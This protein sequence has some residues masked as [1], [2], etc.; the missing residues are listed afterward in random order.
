MISSPTYLS[1]LIIEALVQLQ[2]SKLQKLKKCR[3]CN[4]SWLQGWLWDFGLIRGFG[5]CRHLHNTLFDDASPSLAGILGLKWKWHVD[6]F[7][8]RICRT[9]SSIAKLLLLS[10]KLVETLLTT[11]KC[12]PNLNWIERKWNSRLYRKCP[13]FDRKTASFDNLNMH[14]LPTA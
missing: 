10:Q 1:Q 8:C 13:I 2:N 9:W 12:I 6:L 7:Y 11:S 4:C 14:L 5:H 3:K